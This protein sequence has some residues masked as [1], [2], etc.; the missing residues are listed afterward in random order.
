MAHGVGWTTREKSGRQVSG[1]ADVVALSPGGIWAQTYAAVLVTPE[2]R[3]ALARPAS[4][5]ERTD[6]V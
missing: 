4:G 1:E 6:G 2:V 3:A 5:C